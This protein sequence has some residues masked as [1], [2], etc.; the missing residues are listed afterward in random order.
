MLAGVVSCPRGAQNSRVTDKGKSVSAD[1]RLLL[2]RVQW[3][4][5]PCRKN[6]FASD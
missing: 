6:E 4:D 5:I 2:P 1:L 3:K